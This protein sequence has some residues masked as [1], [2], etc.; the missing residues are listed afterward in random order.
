MSRLPL[1]GIRVL[2]MTVVW[3]GPYCTSFLADLGAEV[4]RIESL[5][6]FAPLTRGVRAHPTETTLRNQPVFMG[7]YP[8]RQ[9]GNRPWNRSPVFNVHARNKLSMTVD[10]SKPRGMEIFKDLA[11]TSDVFVENNVADRMDQL[12]INYDMLKELK[13]DIIMLR[14]PAYGTTGPY[15]DFRALGVHIEGV[16]GHTLLRGYTDMDPSG[17]TPVYMAD[18]A[19]G[20]H[21]AFAVLAALHHRR[22]TG[23]GQYIELG[24]AE[25][26]MPMMGQFFMDYSMNG[27]SAATMGNRHP[28]A[29]QGCYPCLGDDRWVCITIYNDVEWRSFAEALGDPDWAGDPRFAHG[30]GRLEHHDELDAQIG[31]WTKQR[32]NYQV[33]RILQE[34]GVA[35]GPVMD[36]RD[37]YSDP[38]L[39]ERGMFQEAF[40]EDT[41]LNL[42]PRAPYKMSETPP[43]IRRGPVRLGEDNDYVYKTVLGYSDA[44]Y[45][46]LEAEGHISMDYPDHLE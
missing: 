25:D 15:R 36:Q 14:M 6:T 5:A 13:E 11:R 1:E 4:I 21:G 8:D 31:R 7:G 18:A 23:K 37:A 46:E 39:M 32:D 10:L 19:G 34:A 12:G 26:A 2:E 33:M 16:I 29:L 45:A 42:Y 27:R 44:E 40:Q 43:D 24:Q 3:A 38:H 28:T 20:S 30:P 41:G 17:T 22:R 9:P 35:A